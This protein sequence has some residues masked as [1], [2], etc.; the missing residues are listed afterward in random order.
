MNPAL[1]DKSFL[2]KLDNYIIREQ[3][4]KII[5]LNFDELPIGEITGNITQGSITIQGKSACRRTCNL[6]LTTEQSNVNDL[7]W[8]LHSKYYLYV[9]LR[10]YVDDKYDDIIWFPQ[11]MFI[12]TSLS[13]TNNLQGINVSVQGKDKCCL[14]DGSV[15]GALF[16]SHDF[17]TIDVY[18][19]DGT[20]HREILDIKSIVREAVHTYAHEPYENIIINDVD[21]VSVEL[22][23]YK[24]NN[25]KCYIYDSSTDPLF[26][27][28]ST[29][30]TFGIKKR[31]GN[32]Y[33]YEGQTMARIFLK[34]PNLADNYQSELEEVTDEMENHILV[35]VNTNRPAM[36]N[37]EYYRIQKVLNYGDAAG[38]RRTPLTYP[39]GELLI[40]VGGTI[41][42][43]LDK[44]VNVLGE[45]EYFYDI[46]GCFHFQRKKIYHNIS[47]T[48]VHQ[49]DQSIGY[50]NSA[51]TSKTIY[52][53]NNGNIIESYAN[54][55][56]ILNI[57]NDWSLWGTIGSADKNNYPCHLRYAIDDKP[58]GYHCL[59]DDIW[60][61]TSDY[62]LG[63]DI[64]ADD[65]KEYLQL[66]EDYKQYISKQ[67]E[68]ESDINSALAD[69]MER[70]VKKKEVDWREVL[71]R[72][73]VDYQNAQARVETLETLRT[74]F[75]RPIFTTSAIKKLSN[76]K[77]SGKS[78]AAYFDYDTKQLIQLTESDLE[79]INEERYKNEL[80]ALS[81]EEYVI[82]L[83]KTLVFTGDLPYV[84]Q[85]TN[86]LTDNDTSWVN[87]Y[88]FKGLNFKEY[89]AQ[90]Q[91]VFATTEE[92]L[93]L[94]YT[95]EIQLWESRM[96][97]KYAIYFTDLLDFWTLNYKTTNDLTYSDV[98]EDDKKIINGQLTTKMAY[99]G[100]NIVNAQSAFE[101]NIEILNQMAGM[102]EEDKMTLYTEY[103]QDYAN[104]LLKMQQDL[105][106]N[107]K[108]EMWPVNST[109][110]FHWRETL[111]NYFDTQ[112]QN[113]TQQKPVSDIKDTYNNY[114]Y[115]VNNYKLD[116]N[117]QPIKEGEYLEDENGNLITDALGQP[118]KNPKKGQ[119]I[120][121]SGGSYTEQLMT[122]QKGG[123]A[124]LIEQTYQKWVD[125]DY[126][127][128]N[129]IK[130]IKDEFGNA[131][132]EIQFINPEK[133][134]FWIDFLATDGSDSNASCDLAKYKVSVIGHRSKAVKDDK[135]KAISFRTIPPVLF[136]SPDEEV[137]QEQNISYIKLNISGDLAN[138]FSISTQGKSA[139]EELDNM[140]YETTYYQESIT[141]SCLPIY[142]LD[143]NT[144]IRVVDEKSG[145][146][147]EYI[148]QQ[149]TMPLAY[150]ASMSFTANKAAD[151]L[152]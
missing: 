127:N 19:K 60:Y 6:T 25:Y 70:N 5:V 36:F 87:E 148:I 61:H 117:G 138:Y 128:P 100:F 55:P 64:F 89:D 106:N 137:P 131:T 151:R 75:N 142:Y 146:S 96:S 97:S 45:F 78:I 15:G 41:T 84:Q 29:G 152:L 71:Y 134:L 68:N 111:L 65:Y 116:A 13:I 122:E 53:F 46:N 24:V 104:K 108:A 27:T 107:S 83:N 90:H 3:M 28:F 35:S 99:S 9:G 52:D 39:G 120:V 126:W 86:Q 4:A 16:A 110:L 2:L 38:Y 130:S 1:N 12:L 49:E 145:I 91:A 50:F 92:D 14:I 56:K 81:W 72:M 17:G 48:G 143:V 22:V 101:K 135:I 109:A 129:I 98:S 141:I 57:R 144:R 150:N 74:R 115:A 77:N 112:I 139:K 62:K 82:S 51:E 136:V 11:G 140:L 80:P 66:Q 47:W 76:L 118:V 31:Q 21:D 121:N 132:G 73:A 18:E 54:K 44:I 30:M 105:T 26:S 37:G 133:L 43:A 7:D 123:K 114:I 69:F 85:A 93:D 67:Y 124:S 34:D 33:I 79:D 32:S 102:Q 149:I 20:K 88:C 63:D 113:L 40:N 95:K 119:Y 8:Q 103:Y 58:K 42:Q 125:N 23:D 94:M 59:T 147:G 10:N